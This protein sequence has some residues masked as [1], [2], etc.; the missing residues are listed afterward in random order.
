MKKG[1]T[2]E[3]VD[4]ILSAR[5]AGTPAS[6]LPEQLG[7]PSSTVNTV[8]SAHGKTK[9]RPE[10]KERDAERVAK[11]LA[12]EVAQENRP[13]EPV[14]GDEDSD[15]TEDETSVFTVKELR[16]AAKDAGVKGYSRMTRDQLLEVI[17]L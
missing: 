12:Y 5:E 10:I 15:D 8:L 6:K 13:A 17:G 2:Q 14:A 3:Q 4:E 16:A 1:I 11:W 7:I 9:A